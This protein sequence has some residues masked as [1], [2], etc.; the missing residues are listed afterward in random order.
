MFKIAIYDANHFKYIENE[1]IILVIQ[2]NIKVDIEVF[3]EF[4]KA[5]CK[6]RC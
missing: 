1:Q 2:P 5:F 6:E 4:S 3:N